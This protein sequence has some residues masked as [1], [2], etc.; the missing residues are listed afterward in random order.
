[1]CVTEREGEREKE[2]QTEGERERP[3]RVEWLIDAPDR[4]NLGYDFICK[5]L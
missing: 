3:G 4:P 1:M 5:Y 2:R